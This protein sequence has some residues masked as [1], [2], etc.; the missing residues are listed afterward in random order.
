MITWFTP[1]RTLTDVFLMN[2]KTGRVSDVASDPKPPSQTLGT[3]KIIA[4]GTNP[5]P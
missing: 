5:I 4:K 3:V 2:F 1:K